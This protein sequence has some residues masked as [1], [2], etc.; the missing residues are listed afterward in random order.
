[1]YNIGSSPTLTSCTFSSNSAVTGAGGGMCNY[2]SNPT[3]TNCSF[4]GN[5][6]N[7]GGVIYNGNSSPTLTNCTFSGNSADYGGG[8]LNYESNPTV[9]NCSFSANSANHGGGMYNYNSSPILTNCILWGNTSLNGPQIYNDT[10]SPAVS[11]SD[12]Q[13][14]WEGT[15]NINADPLFVDAND[16]NLRLSPDSP[17]IDAGNNT[18]I[19]TGIETDLDGRNRFADGDCNSTVI[20]DMGAFEF[21]YA[22]IGDFE[23]D[24]DIDLV[25]FA[26]LAKAWL[27]E[28]GQ[29]DYNPIC[30][31]SSPADQKI[32][33]F[34]LEVFC[35]NWLQGSGE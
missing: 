17:C 35:E 34:D 33:M 24:C 5:S 4:S 12:V 3:V 29:T 10:S 11:F 14:G 19:P 21:S 30:N 1:M 23:G 6:A 9:T 32:D 22:Y 8:M 31:I 13:D 15:G 20:V 18:A 27:T 2:E 28:E 7:Y 25:D 26:I 16:D